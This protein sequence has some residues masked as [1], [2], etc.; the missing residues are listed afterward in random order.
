MVRVADIHFTNGSETSFH[1]SS[2]YLSLNAFIQTTYACVPLQFYKTENSK[3]KI[4]MLYHHD[5]HV[6]FFIP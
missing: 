3:H 4:I 2:L 6:E 1:F 5:I